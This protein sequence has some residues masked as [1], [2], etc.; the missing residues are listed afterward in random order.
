MARHYRRKPR[1]LFIPSVLLVGCLFIFGLFA[2]IKATEK[3]SSS[4]IS[5]VSEFVRSEG[6]L[7]AAYKSCLDFTI[8]AL[9]LQLVDQEELNPKGGLVKALAAVTGTGLGDSNK[10]ADYDIKLIKAAELENDDEILSESPPL[11]EDEI[12][13]FEELEKK[14]QDAKIANPYK[15]AASAKLPQVLIYNTHNSETYQPTFGVEKVEGK[16]GGVE[17]VAAHL[18]QVLAT[19]YGILS[20]R[21]TTIHDYPDWEKSYVNSAKTVKQCLNENPSVQ[22]V[23]DIHR[24][25]GLPQ[26]GVIATTTGAKMAKLLLVVG[27]D[28]QLEHPTWK[29]N[30]QFAKMVG[31]KL[32]KLYPDLLKAV[33]VQS[34][35]YNQHLHQRSL[36]VEVGCTQNRLDEALLS[37]EALADVIYEVLL[38][39]QQENTL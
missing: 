20:V 11:T 28:S 22:I 1:L 38:D 8:P 13:F 15:G 19:K 31:Y 27:S 9:S 35:R 6:V 18:E 24:D 39:L 37:A 21:P 3:I 4:I 30:W 33:R 29:E 25:A 7:T 16:N 10:P 23:L 5:E 26:K 36:L 2:G 12:R 34:G 32:D 17:Q 14:S